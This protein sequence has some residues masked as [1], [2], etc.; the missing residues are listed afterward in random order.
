MGVEMETSTQVL[1]GIAVAIVASLGGFAVYKWR[2]RQR[3]RQ[4]KKWLENYLIVRFGEL[5]N[6]LNI[7]CSD[8]P[9]WPVLVA[10]S[11]PRTGIRHKLQ[12]SCQDPHRTCSLLSEVEEK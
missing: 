6:P 12:F 10:F 4:V 7:N 1:I 3:V 8:D 5:P 2:Q 11:S 9:L